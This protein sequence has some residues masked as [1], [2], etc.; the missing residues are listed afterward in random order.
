M[1]CKDGCSEDFI[2]GCLSYIFLFY[3][4]PNPIQ[5]PGICTGP[6]RC[7]LSL[8]DLLSVEGNTEGAEQQPGVS[9]VCGGSVDRNVEARNHL[10]RVPFCLDVS[11]FSSPHAITGSKT[12]MS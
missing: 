7:D 3:D 4:H 11:L 6:S 10:G 5:T 9:V 12:Y 2:H 1:Y 8:V